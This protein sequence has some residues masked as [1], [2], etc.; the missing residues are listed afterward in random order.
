[1]VL[2]VNF[3]TSGSATS[4]TGTEE[5]TALTF[6]TSPGMVIQDMFQTSCGTVANDADWT[7]YIDG[8]QTR[9]KWS[10][11]E[12][13]PASVGRPKVSFSIGPNKTVQF[14]WSGQ[15]AA[16]ANTLKILYVVA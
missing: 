10:A 14:K 16:A 2:Q 13:N 1:M 12:L 9:Y 8:S 3:L 4:G 7:L 6:I 11:E 5:L 15:S